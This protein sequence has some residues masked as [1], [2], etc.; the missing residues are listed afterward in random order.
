MS[1]ALL[2]ITPVLKRLAFH[3][4]QKGL[5]SHAVEA[6]YNVFYDEI[7]VKPLYDWTSIE[8]HEPQGGLVVEFWWVGKRIRWVEFGAHVIGGGGDPIL[9]KI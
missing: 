4:L 8:G 5:G 7:I 3:Y 9:R 2:G 6:P 1:E